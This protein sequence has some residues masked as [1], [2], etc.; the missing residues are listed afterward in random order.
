MGL[1]RLRPIKR[2]SSIDCKRVTLVLQYRERGLEWLATRKIS[3][4]LKNS[5][6]AIAFMV[7]SR[8]AS[9]FAILPI[10]RSIILEHPRKSTRLRPRSSAARKTSILILTQWFASRPDACAR[11]S[12]NTM[13]P[14]EQRTKFWSRCPG[15][16]M[17]SLFMT[18]LREMAGTT[19]GPRTRLQGR[20]RA[21]PQPLARGPL[22]LLSCPS[23]SPSSWPLLPTA[24]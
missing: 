13:P 21:R 23:F 20:R 12:R 7:R 5:S 1:I 14:R 17:L 10:S 11:N 2:Y 4:R 15:E 8:C 9:C 6:A 18:A 16:T 19:S 24:Y 22:R 3:L